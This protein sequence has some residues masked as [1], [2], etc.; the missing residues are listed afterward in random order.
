MKIDLDTLRGFFAP[1]FMVDLGIVPV[2]VGEGRVATELP[3]AP[4][5]LQHTGQVHA[6]VMARWPTTA[7][8]RRRRRWPPRALDP[9][10]RAV[11]QPAA[12]RQG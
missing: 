1:P 8:A 10:G 3:L 5:H 4:R 9:H 7:W 12:R 6:G 11:D 2:A